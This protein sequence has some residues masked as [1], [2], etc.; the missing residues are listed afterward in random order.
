MEH[1]ETHGL[2][3]SDQKVVTAV[4]AAVVDYSLHFNPPR[5]SSPHPSLSQPKQLPPQLQL[6]QKVLQQQAKMT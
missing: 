5:T 6:Q 3:V 2:S 1:G 4:A